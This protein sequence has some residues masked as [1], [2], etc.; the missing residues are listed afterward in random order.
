MSKRYNSA[1][2]LSILKKYGITKLYHFTDRDNLDSIIANGG[3]YSW[4]DCEDLSIVIPK[5]GGSTSSRSLD[6]RDGLQHYVRLSFTPKHPMMFAAMNDGRISNP[7]ILEI[8]LDVIVDDTTKFSDRNATKNGANVGDDIEAFKRIHFNSFK[9]DTH[10]DL[11]PE[12][13]MYFQAEIL[14]FFSKL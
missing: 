1:D 8:N 11:P 2:F 4:A 3:L 14:V 13:Q 7:I 6:L 12:E 9:A 10:F 5:P